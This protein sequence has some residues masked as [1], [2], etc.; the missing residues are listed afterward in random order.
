MLVPRYSHAVTDID[1]GH[2][3][4]NTCL[5]WLKTSTTPI[6]TT[7]TTTTTT[8]PSKGAAMTLLC[9]VRLLIVVAMFSCREVFN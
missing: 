3:I 7:T 1:I 2:E 6:T 9:D 4:E 5:D 8:T